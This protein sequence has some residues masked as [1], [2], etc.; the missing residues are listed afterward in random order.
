MES[1]RIYLDHNATTPLRE[2]VVEAM[3]R[4]LRDLPGNPSSPHREGTLARKQVAEAREQ[5]ADC[6]GTSARTIV[7]TGGAT[8]A[9]HFL[10]RGV[11]GHSGSMDSSHLVTSTTEHPS[12]LAPAEQLEKHGLRVS[13]IP[14]DHEG[15]LE[16]SVWLETL[17]ES[18][19]LASLIW[20]NNETGVVQPVE[21]WAELASACGILFHVD[22]TQA[23][24]KWPICL[25]KTS[26]DYLSCS[27][28]K[29]NGPKG[30]GCLVHRSGPAPSP[31][32]AGGGQE[33]GLRGGTENVAG[34]VGFGVACELARKELTERM[35][36][37]QILRDRLWD[38]LR[39]K[40]PRIRRNGPSASAILPNT[41]NVEIPGIQADILVEALDLEGVAVSA[42]AAC[43][44]GSVS[45]SH[46]LIAMGRSTAQAQAS[47][48]LSVGL[49][50]TSVEID[51]A[52]DW[53]DRIARRAGAEGY[54][55]G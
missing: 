50:N 24:G 30:V 51:R 10:L 5:V 44:S 26:I 48:R 54:D 42:G 17:E 45:P 16:R 14:V 53:I 29:L 6:L 28:H 22:A 32:L 46:V 36:N 55:G 41:L 20:A 12:V 8:E 39:Q 25:E 40:L 33:R 2:E 34:I 38:S 31:L 23:V 7:F 15:M 1:E 52:A 18:P 9:N 43:H 13:R 27:A 19:S 37:Y 3:A 49:G 4:A 21:E 35:E 47:L 11:L